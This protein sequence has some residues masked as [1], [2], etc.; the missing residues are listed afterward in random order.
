MPAPP[1]SVRWNGEAP[2]PLEVNAPLMKLD[3]KLRQLA[4]APELPLL[5][6]QSLLGLSSG[7]YGLLVGA[8]SMAFLLIP[9]LVYD[10]PPAAQ[11]DILGSALFFSSSYA[12]LAGFMAP[13]VRGA[14]ADLDALGSVLPVSEGDRCIL[15][16][17][18][19]RLPTPALLRELALGLIA[20]SI[21]CYLLGHLQLPW[22]LM[23]GQV[24]ATLLLWV[25]MFLTVP[26]LA[27]NALLFS[28]LGRCAEPD[29][30]RPSR[31]AAFGSAAL[32]PALLLIGTLCAYVVLFLENGSSLEP[33]TLIGALVSLPTLLGI[34]AL[35]LR[36]IRQR[37]RE[38]RMNS[39]LALDQR[40][41]SITTAPLATL[42]TSTLQDMDILLD[43]R[44][45]IAQAPGWPL[46]L[47]GVQ[48]ILLYIVLPPLTWVAAAM[49]EML[50]DALV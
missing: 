50:V 4:E 42:S 28:R 9:F 22:V 15:A 40:L 14:A 13:V 23:L 16:R 11:R 36:G 44:E 8:V 19:S 21:H 18:L 43:M 25:L 49:V 33:T 35:P 32:R 46:D 37:I 45:R 2:T 48:R 41:E 26:K 10:L 27:T 5:R 30:L 31:H 6:L 17:G 3:N 47:A 24:V 20:G 7:A 38:T 29:L 1:T 39:L 12:I 34:I